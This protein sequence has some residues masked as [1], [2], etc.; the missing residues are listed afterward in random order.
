M[1][2]A[3]A[4]SQ[5]PQTEHD[6]NSFLLEF[7]TVRQQIMIFTLRGILRDGS[8]VDKPSGALKFFTRTFTVVPK[9][10]DKMAIVNDEL[11]LTPISQERF[12]KYNEQLRKMTEVVSD[13]F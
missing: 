10:D 2:I 9:A 4:L 11:M 5:L 6:K 13:S 12:E 3:V 8:D 7:I 1:A